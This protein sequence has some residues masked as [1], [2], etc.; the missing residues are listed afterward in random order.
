MF[1][2]QASFVKMPIQ[3]LSLEEYRKNGEQL[4]YRVTGPCVCQSPWS[5][6]LPLPAAVHTASSTW[7]C[8]HVTSMLGLLQT[9]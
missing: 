1:E 8:E 6:S 3:T 9:S 5:R 2:S 7:P 4:S